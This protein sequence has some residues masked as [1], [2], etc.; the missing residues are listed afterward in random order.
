MLPEC[1]VHLSSLV[2]NFYTWDLYVSL[3]TVMTLRQFRDWRIEWVRQMR[4][5]LSLGV[6]NDTNDDNAL[7]L[8][9][10]MVVQSAPIRLFLS[11]IF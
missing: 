7:R 11:N 1:A 10:G 8:L 5:K 2:L 9:K 6:Q 4:L 3:W